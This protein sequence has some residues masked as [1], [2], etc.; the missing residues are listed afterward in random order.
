MQR[1]QRIEADQTESDLLA[2]PSAECVKVGEIPAAP[3]S[4]RAQAI[5]GDVESGGSP[6]ASEPIRDVGAIRT[7]N[8]VAFGH[9]AA[10]NTETDAVIPKRQFDGQGKLIGEPGAMV[11]RDLTQHLQ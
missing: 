10:I 1:V 9:G 6:A 2:G 3:I 4:V 5:E 8:Q 11:G 7:N